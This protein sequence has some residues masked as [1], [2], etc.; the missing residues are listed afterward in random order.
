MPM[1]IGYNK[2]RELL[3]FGDQIDAKTALDP[4]MVNRIVPVAELREATRR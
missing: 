2:A 3:C 1:I 4:G